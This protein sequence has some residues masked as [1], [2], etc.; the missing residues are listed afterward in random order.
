[1][2]SI[3]RIVRS[4]ICSLC[5]LSVI[6][7]FAGNQYFLSNHFKQHQFVVN[8]SDNRQDNKKN[9]STSAISKTEFL[10]DGVVA[11][12][13]A[14]NRSLPCFK[15]DLPMK[16]QNGYRKPA[17]S[18][19]LFMK[20][21]KTGGS[22]AT[23][24]TMRIAKHTAE[25]RHEKFWICRGRWDHNWAFKMLKERRRDDSFTWTVLREPT[26]RAISEF[27]HFEVSRNKVSSSDESFIKYLTKG[28]HSRIQ[29]NLYLRVLSI[30]YS[31]SV[32]DEDAPSIINAILSDYDFIG[33]TERM[34]ESV[35]ALAMLL[36]L[37]LGDVLY[38]DAKGH[39]GYDDGVYNNTCVYIKPSILSP[40]MRNFFGN[41]YWTDMIK[42]DRLLYDAS[43]RSL[44]LTIDGLGRD[45]F[46]KNLIK[47]R[48]ANQVAR[49]RCLPLNVFP[50][51]ST[52][53]HNKNA[54]CLWSDSGCGYKCLDEVALEHGIA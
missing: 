44:D 41:E 34:D 40:R 8:V 27:Y 20:L 30:D 3:A 43:N 39:G 33:I 37:P 52:G 16:Q 21:V 7:I 46:N 9:V 11:R 19:L 13:F 2:T 6:F 10:Q 51:T 14:W 47:F 22:T 18:G 42:W 48:N 31:Y 50:C 1:M 17:T 24:I 5:A 25:R 12:A 38:L 32:F 53:E 29:R 23:G 15:P 26:K 54:S 36:N 49:D 28:E 35:V 4:F 45:A